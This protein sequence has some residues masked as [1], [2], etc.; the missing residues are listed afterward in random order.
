MRQ[1]AEGLSDG[2]DEM[3]S[4]GSRTG[5][6]FDARAGR[7]VGADANL[8]SAQVAADEVDLADGMQGRAQMVA[9]GQSL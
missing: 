6:E 3:Q 1:S 7:L 8:T 5:T 9:V 4:S 2:T